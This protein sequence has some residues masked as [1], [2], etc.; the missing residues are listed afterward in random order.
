MR[1]VE[2][3]N[4]YTV[5]IALVI[6]TTAGKSSACSPRRRPKRPTTAKATAHYWAITYKTPP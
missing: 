4:L 2:K 1:L 6:P 3:A 5:F